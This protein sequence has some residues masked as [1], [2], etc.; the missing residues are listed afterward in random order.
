[1]LGA[2]SV[3]GKTGWDIQG[4][5]QLAH[6]SDESFGLFPGAVPGEGRQFFSTRGQVPLQ[7]MRQQDRAPRL[8][9]RMRP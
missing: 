5:S 9:K 1:M 8:R 6:C 3:F 7:H 4:L 2:E